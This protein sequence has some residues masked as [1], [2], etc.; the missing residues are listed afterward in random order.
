MDNGAEIYKGI[1]DGL[2]EMSKSC[3][4]ATAVRNGKV[5]GVDAA[6]SGI[7]EVLY[8]LN[9]Q[10][11][12]VLAD[13]ILETYHAGI[14]DTLEQLEWLSCC[15]DMVITVEGQ[16][17]PLDKYEGIPNDYIGRCSDWEWPDE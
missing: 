4:D 2:V 9:K 8:K 7:N 14:Y 5:S 17:L 13:F 15:K 11:L 12:N 6:K 3:V 10:E 1:I 16:T